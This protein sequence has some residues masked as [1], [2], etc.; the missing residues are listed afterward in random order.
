MQ[1]YQGPTIKSDFSKRCLT[2]WW[3]LRWLKGKWWTSLLLHLCV[4]VWGSCQSAKKSYCEIYLN[5]VLARRLY[6]LRSSRYFYVVDRTI[7][8]WEAA[9]T[10]TVPP[11]T[12]YNQFQ[13][14]L[15][16]RTELIHNKRDEEDSITIPHHGNMD[17]LPDTHLRT[18]L[19]LQFHFG[20]TEFP[21]STIRDVKSKA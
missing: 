19:L 20:Y 21:M 7:L 6:T 2:L 8:S 16:H 1:R 10:Q 3:S 4:G 14:S 12:L 18:S 13:T 9:E 5:D 15:Q 11:L 17:P